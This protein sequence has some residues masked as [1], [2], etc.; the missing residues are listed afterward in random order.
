MSNVTCILTSCGRFDLLRITLD[1]FFKFNTYEITEFIIYEDSGLPVPQDLKDDYPFIQWFVPNESTGQISALD[2]LW[3]HV[4]TEYAFTMEDD[5]EFLKE[6]FI[7]R[8]MVVM[9]LDES[10]LMVWLKEPGDNNQHPIVW[11]K[12]YGVF[13]RGEPL[14][15]WH[16]FNPSL[17]RK[18]DYD[19][20]APFSKHTTFNKN[21]GWKSEAAISKVYNDLGF[22]A[23][24][25]PTRYIK[26]LG[27]GRRVK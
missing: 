14:W 12:D 15:A 23:A 24:I 16:R 18:K 11:Y 25:L 19:L 4:K 13:K 26:H 21:K 3:F 27:E 17:K 8:S 7:E 1:S 6:G 20:I 22:T 2:T 10:F 5:W 9:E